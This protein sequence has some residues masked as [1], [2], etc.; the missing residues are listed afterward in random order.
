VVNS[1]QYQPII[2]EWLVMGF[3]ETYWIYAGTEVHNVN[4]QE[5]EYNKYTYNSELWGDPIVVTE[6][7]RFEVEV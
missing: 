3:D 5:V 6:Y 7:W 4:G 1:Y 2:G